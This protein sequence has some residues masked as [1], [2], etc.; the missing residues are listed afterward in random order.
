M[1]DQKAIAAA[2]EALQDRYMT[3][4]MCITSTECKAHNRAIDTALAC[5]R[6]C[7]ERRERA[8][9]VAPVVRC[10]DCIWFMPR[11]I[12][13]SDETITYVAENADFVTMDV[14][15]NYQATCRRHSYIDNLYVSDSGNDYCSYGARMDGGDT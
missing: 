13:H 8:A 12:L 14:G 6:E 5:M 2:I 15:I 4:S 7:A 1:I 3:V 10:K 11:H 9:D